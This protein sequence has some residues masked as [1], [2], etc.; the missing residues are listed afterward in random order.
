MK[1][2]VRE[3]ISLY[4]YEFYILYKSI[5]GNIPEDKIINMVNQIEELNIFM[6]MIK[7][8]KR[9]KINSLEGMKHS[10]DFYK[11]SELKLIYNDKP[12]AVISSDDKILFN[13]IDLKL[14]NELKYKIN[15]LNKKI[16]DIKNGY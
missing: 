16:E 12:I 7:A 9:Y 10:K 13:V 1:I 3:R 6:D 14:C 11:F 2:V 8:N 4:P 15:E 5:G